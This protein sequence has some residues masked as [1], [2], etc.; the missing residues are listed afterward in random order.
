MKGMRSLE[1]V[2]VLE[3]I[4]ILEQRVSSERFS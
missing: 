3:N 1:D 4:L 2:M